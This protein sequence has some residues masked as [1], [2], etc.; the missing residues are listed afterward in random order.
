[1]FVSD[2]AQSCSSGGTVAINLV[3]RV[4]NQ[5]KGKSAFNNLILLNIS[6]LFF[7]NRGIQE[8][9][10]KFCFYSCCFPIHAEKHLLL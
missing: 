5:L 2:M 8:A 6:C 10:G 1:M 4:Q 7:F 9:A 3:C